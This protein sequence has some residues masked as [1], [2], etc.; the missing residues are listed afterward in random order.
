MTGKSKRVRR[1][2][3]PCDNCDLRPH[4]IFAKLPG[5][6][7]EQVRRSVTVHHYQA[8]QGL[9]YEEAPALALRS[10]VKGTVKLYKTGPRQE[11]LVIRVLGPG[12]LLGFRPILAGEPYSA[13]AEALDTTTVCSLTRDTFLDLLRKSTRLSLQIMRKLAVELRVSEEQALAMSQLSVK[14]RVARFLLNLRDVAGGP[15]ETGARLDILLTRTEM[16]Q[17]IGATPETL[18]RTLRALADD[19]AINV[20]RQEIFIG[21]IDKLLKA[22]R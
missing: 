15:G 11:Q 5:S 2:D 13:S 7:Q 6:L 10:I 20:T 17:M 16:A 4:C 22:A 21:N 9:F 12:E 18:S 1:H 3:G 14:Q 8:G 19:K